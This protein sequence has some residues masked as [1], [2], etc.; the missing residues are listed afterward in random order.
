MLLLVG[1]HAAAAADISLARAMHHQ[2]RFHVC[3]ATRRG[4]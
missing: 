4:G 2:W 3:I 1:G